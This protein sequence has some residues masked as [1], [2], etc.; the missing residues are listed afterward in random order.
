MSAERRGWGPD[1]RLR[2]WD[3]KRVGERERE[4]SPNWQAPPEDWRG[5]ARGDQ[6][7]PED[8]EAW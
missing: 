7:R 4:Q 8:F 1:A 2:P 5:W 6:R 3:K